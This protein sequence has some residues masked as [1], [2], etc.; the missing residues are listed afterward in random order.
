M[1]HTIYI[2]VKVEIETDLPIEQ[3][4]D[5]FG[6][7]SLYNFDSTENVAILNTEWLDISTQE[8]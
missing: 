1:K 8:I 7:E 3:A 2:K 4:L 6:S 5:E